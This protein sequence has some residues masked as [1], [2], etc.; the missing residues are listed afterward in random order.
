MRLCVLG[1]VAAHLLGLAAQSAAAGETIKLCSSGT[2]TL[3]GFEEHVARLRKSGRYNA[4]EINDLIS[5]KRRGGPRFFS[6]QVVIK[7]EQSSSGDFDLNLF[8]GF[9]DPH[10]K[11]RSLSPWA[12]EAEDYPVAYFVGF[13]VREIGDGAIAVT[14]EPGVVNVVSLKDLDPDLDRHTRVRV[15]NGEATLCQ[16]I[17]KGCIGSIFYGRW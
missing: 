1:L 11:Y 7:E 13:K 10:A 6:T 5:R 4:A 12:C 15:F 14:P 2:I 17:A 8:Q 3:G 9:S 16:D